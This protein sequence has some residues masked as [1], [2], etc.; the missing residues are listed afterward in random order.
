MRA[1]KSWLRAGRLVRLLALALLILVGSRAVSASRSDDGSASKTVADG[2]EQLVLADGTRVE[3]LPGQVSLQPVETLRRRS[4]LGTDGRA[5]TEVID[6]LDFEDGTFP[7]ENWDVDDQ[8]TRTFGPDSVDAW[9]R[10]ICQTD[11]AE[12]GVAAAWAAGGG[13]NGP[14]LACGQ[15]LGKPF[16]TR[17]FRDGVDTS[18]YPF[19]VQVDFTVYLDLPLTGDS[20]RAMKVCWRETN[21]NQAQCSSIVINDARLLKRWLGLS[22]PIQFAEAANK[23]SIELMFWFDDDAGTGDYAGAFIDNVRIEG[24]TEAPPPTP[25]SQTTNTPGPTTPAISPTPTITR[26]P[27]ERAKIAFLPMLLKSADKDD[28]SQIPSQYVQV[29][30]GTAIDASDRVEN[31]GNQFQYG[32]MRLCAQVNWF[33]W[34]DSTDIRWQWYQKSGSRFEEIPSSTLNDSVLVGQ[35]T[36][37]YASRC[38]RA[39]DAE[40]EDV[41]IWLN[42]Y[43]VDVF[44]DGV[45]PA[46][47]SEIAVIS[48]E[49]P[50][51]KTARPPSPTPWPTGQ[52]S[53]TPTPKATGGPPLPGGCSTVIEN[54]DFERGS[55][56]G[57]TLATNAN[58]TISD[59]I[60]RGADLGLNAAGGDW[61]A[62]MGRGANVRDQ[63]ISVPFDFPEAGQMISATLNFSFG[64][65]TQETRNGNHD[66][67]LIAALVPRDGGQASTIPGTGISE[68][69]IDADSWYSLSTP[70]DMTQLL[71]AR[72]GWSGAQLLF[73]SQNSA[74]APSAHILDEIELVLCVADAP[75]ATSR[76]A[77]GQRSAGRPALRPLSGDL[78]MAPPA[79]FRQGPRL[80]LTGHAAAPSLLR[81]GTR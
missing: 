76:Q 44:V 75:L 65:V 14:N 64:L 74:D 35:E 12:G 52:P 2:S 79:S 36:R 16:G 72:A 81:L 31:I 59:V 5:Q 70:I 56:V 69:L 7:P 62:I 55:A 3:L 25:T 15:N 43:K 28:P 49:P 66:D 11:P 73:Q 13:S 46:A 39:V 4:G 37:P 48:Q 50:P 63:L 77:T 33:G 40:G 6:E 67:T 9:S 60:A 34:P 1:S 57:W 19:G 47:V 21:S 41:P 53:P 68:E 30:F 24:L 32:A 17:L 10:Q 18:S 78:E 27:T 45:L 23:A 61:L 51:G 54:A 20:A 26:T 8:I 29:W 58:K 80:D 71:T 22:A 38:I 42:E